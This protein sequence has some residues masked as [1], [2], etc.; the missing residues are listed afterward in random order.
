[1]KLALGDGRFALRARP[2]ELEPGGRA[3]GAA[4]RSRT[5]WRTRRR[6]SRSRSRSSRRATRTR[7]CTA[8]ASDD[9]RLLDAYIFVGSRKVFYRSNRNGADPKQ[10]AFDADLPLRPGV[11]VVTVVARENPDTTTRRTFI[12]RRDGPNGELLA[13]AEDRRRAQRDGLGR[14]RLSLT[15]SSRPPPRQRRPRRDAAQRA[16]HAVSRPRARRRG[17]PRGGRRRHHGA[18]ARGPA[19]HRR[20]RRRARCARSARGA[21]ARSTWRWRRPTRWSRIATARE[22]RRVHAG[23]RAARRAHDRGR[24]RRG[25]RAATRSRVASR[26]SSAAGIKV[27]LFIAADA[28]AD[29]RGRAPLGAAQIEL[30]TGEY[31]HGRRRASSRASPAG[32][33]RSARALGLEVAAGHGL[34]QEN[35]PALVAIPEIVELNI[36]HAVVSDARVRRARPGGAGVPR[37][38]RPGRRPPL[39]SLDLGA[40]INRRATVGRMHVGRPSLEARGRGRA[41]ASC[42]GATCDTARRRPGN[43]AARGT[44]VCLGTY[45]LSPKSRSG[46]PS[47]AAL[48]SVH[49]VRRSPVR[50]RSLIAGSLALGP[51]E[52]APGCGGRATG[53]RELAARTSHLPLVRRPLRAFVSRFRSNPD[54]EAHARTRLPGALANERRVAVNERRVPAPFARSLPPFARSLSPFARSLPPFARS[55][56]PFARSLPPFAR[57]LPPFARGAVNERRSRHLSLIRCHLSLIRRHPSFVIPITKLVRTRLAKRACAPAKL[58]CK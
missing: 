19:P 47:P 57:S 10:M 39:T 17:V 25:R 38:H 35:V 16:R 50:S 11:N 37:R 8:T 21:D 40:G 54:C 53:S 44:A 45:F 6:R 30:H 13:D 20:R 43:N 23:A 32:A 4:S 22:A 33:Q 7:W 28:D 1:M 34:T 2:S 29:R 9:A 41:P 14:R 58:G 5:R 49:W 36:G 56:S 12:V 24:A 46:R 55:L 52:R 15:R 26:R 51:P 42:F 3:A 18:P 31:A 27:S 48:H